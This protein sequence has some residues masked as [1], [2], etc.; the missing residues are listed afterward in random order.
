[1]ERGYQAMSTHD[2]ETIME[3]LGSDYNRINAEHVVG[4]KRTQGYFGIKY[5]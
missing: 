1:M 4:N 5:M 3:R 2:W